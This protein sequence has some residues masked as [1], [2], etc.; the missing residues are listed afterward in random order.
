VQYEERACCEEF[1]TE[2]FAFIPSTPSS[3]SIFQEAMLKLQ[4]GLYNCQLLMPN[5]KRSVLL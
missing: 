5:I 2:L 1:Q 4:S 3:F